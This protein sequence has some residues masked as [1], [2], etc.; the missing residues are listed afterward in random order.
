MIDYLLILGY[1]ILLVILNVFLF[2]SMQNWFKGSLFVAQFAGFLMVTFP[3]SIYFIICDSVLGHQS[4]GKR[5]VGIKVVN[6]S[7]GSPTLFRSIFRV[8][9]KF[10]P[11]ELSHF[12]V[13]RL[14]MI[15]E[16]EVPISYS[17]IGGIIYSLMFAYILTAILTKKK[18]S[19]YD[20][21]SKTQVVR[22][23]ES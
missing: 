14:V 7:G 3:V 19:L 18:Q 23:S 8:M 22:V 6:E 2:P 1:L 17:V 20:L 5:K 21:I 13:Y 9:L 15:G 16:N 10:L 12:L 11:W 4:F